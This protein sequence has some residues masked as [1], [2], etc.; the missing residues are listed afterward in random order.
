MN[1]GSEW[2]RWEPHIHAPGTVLADRYGKTSWSTYL[3]T[4]EA[5]SPTLHAIGVTDYCLSRSYEWVQA[6]KDKGRLK[7]YDLLFPN[8]ELRLGVQCFCK[9]RRLAETACGCRE[10]A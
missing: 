5:V 1:R 7:N 2:R 6:E 3:D 10:T 9:R 4:L 8:I